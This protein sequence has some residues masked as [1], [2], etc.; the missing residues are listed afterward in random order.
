[1]IGVIKVAA[2]DGPD[3][4]PATRVPQETLLATER[5][6]LSILVWAGRPMHIDSS[7]EDVFAARERSGTAFTGGRR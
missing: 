5:G 2:N 3:K 7:W 1:M 4:S 6:P